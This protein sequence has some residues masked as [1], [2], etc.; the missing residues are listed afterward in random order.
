[1]AQSGTDVDIRSSG[2]DVRSYLRAG[3][4]LLPLALIAAV[5]AGYALRLVHPPTLWLDEAMLIVNVRDIAWRNLFAPLPFYDQAAPIAY[6][7]LL[8]L[9]HGLA[10]LHEALL[11]LPSLAA[12]LVTLALIARLPGTCR[13]TRV[14]AAALLAGSF[15]TARIATDVKPYMFEALFAF[16]MMI[17]LSLIHISEPTRLH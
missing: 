7:A 16:A 12:L 14:L 11:R 6:V 15:V 1:M 13:T 4:H 9:I 3:L 8:K 2:S 17:A 5:V 10:G